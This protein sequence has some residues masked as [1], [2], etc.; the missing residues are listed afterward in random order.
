MDYSL[1]SS[2]KTNVSE[3]ENSSLG[4]RKRVREKFMQ[5]DVTL[6]SNTEIIEALLFFAI[7]EEM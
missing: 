5:Q 6:F 3:E 7:Q 1:K 4:H 2:K